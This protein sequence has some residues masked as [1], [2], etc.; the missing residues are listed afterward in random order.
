MT[1]GRNGNGEGPFV[2]IREEI[3]RWKSDFQGPV[4]RLLYYTIGPE[5][6]G[7]FSFSPNLTSERNTEW[8]MLLDIRE[9]S[10]LKCTTL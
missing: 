7:H 9:A 8:N 1:E 3:K 10:H 5:A 4:C 6:L 2:E